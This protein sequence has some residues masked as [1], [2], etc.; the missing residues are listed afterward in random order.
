MRA[1]LLQIQR[2]LPLLSRPLDL[3]GLLGLLALGPALAQEAGRAGAAAV[4]EQIADF[5][6]QHPA[7][8]GR[9]IDVVWTLRPMTLPP[10]PAGIE[11]SWSGTAR[12]PGAVRL[13]A[14]CPHGPKPW[15]RQLAVQAQL[16]S[17]YWVARRALPAGHR[18]QPDDLEAVFGNTARLPRGLAGARSA[19]E[20]QELSR[21]LGAGEALQLN[22]LRLQTVIRR[23]MEVQV[24]VLG[25]GFEIMTVGVA[26]SDAAK[27][28]TLKIKTQD[29]RTLD[30]QAV[31]EGQAEVRMD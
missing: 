11:L 1:C 25:R 24:K 30:A 26:L 10:C 13:D 17:D 7:L 27:G 31:G 5:V 19:W 9:K 28:S 12:P 15:Q 4:P 14:S 8:A 6:R 20:G 16:W 22:N 21:A 18:V 3:L 23:S 29:G 2:R